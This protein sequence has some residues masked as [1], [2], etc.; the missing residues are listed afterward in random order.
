MSTVAQSRSRRRF[1]AGVLSVPVAIAGSRRWGALAAEYD[2][3]DGPVT[4]ADEGLQLLIEGNKRFVAG[5]LTAFDDLAADR[6]EVVE[7]QHPFAVIVSCSDS[8]VPA[9]LIFD[10]TFGQLFVVRTAGQVIDEAARG[11]ISYGIDVLR[12]PLVVVLGHSGCGAVEAAIAALDG[13]PIPGYAYRFAEAIGPAVQ[14]VADEPGDLL[15]NAIR[16]N[17]E[18]GVERLQTAEPTLAAAV[19]SDQ[20]MVTGGYYDLASGEVTFLD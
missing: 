7:G 17:I 16:A 14:A 11:S 8:R 1:V 20:I 13:Q 9:E 10:Q 5:E 6:T 19:S 12:A 3:E 15:N 2:Y 4:P 18:L